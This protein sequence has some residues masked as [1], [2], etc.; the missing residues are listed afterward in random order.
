MKSCSSPYINKSINAQSLFISFQL[1]ALSSLKKYGVGTCGPRGFYGTFGW[2]IYH[3]KYVSRVTAS[4]YSTEMSRRCSS[5][6]RGAIGEVHEN[7]GGHYLLVWLRH[8]RQRYSCVLQE[9]RHHLCVR[10]Q[11][12]TW[13]VLRWASV[14]ICPS[15]VF[16][17]TRRRVSPFRKACRLHAASS[18]TSNTTIWR[19]LS[20]CW[21]SRRLK[22]RRWGGLAHNMSTS[23]IFLVKHVEGQFSH[24]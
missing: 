23:C 10:T 14:L 7:R 24:N 22:T 16:S 19:I 20:A 5:G 4:G 12:L 8:Y 17:A 3:L 2:W 13:D 1:K 9:R 6:V 11:L 18:S 21:R 15:L